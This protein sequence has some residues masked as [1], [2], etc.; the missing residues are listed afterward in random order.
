MFCQAPKIQ[1]DVFPSC[2]AVPPRKLTIDMS[3]QIVR[4]SPLSV[5]QAG[6]FA[7]TRVEATIGILK[8]K[9]WGVA[10]GCKKRGEG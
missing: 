3:G 10:Y 8:K 9:E 6:F 7:V 4:M 2:A 1:P 5:R